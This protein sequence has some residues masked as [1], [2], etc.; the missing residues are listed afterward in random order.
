MNEKPNVEIGSDQELLALIGAGLDGDAPPARVLLVPWGAVQSSSGDFVVDEESA[1]LVTEAFGAHG[2]DLPID[3]EHQTL[4]GAYTSPSGQAPAAGWIKR[5]EVEEGVGIFAEVAWTPPAA[6]QL[7]ARQYRYLSPVALIRKSDRRL[8]A[9][10]SAALTNKPAIAH[11][12][13]IVNHEGTKG[14]SNC[15]LRISDC[16]LCKTTPS[17]AQVQASL[18]AANVE[19]EAALDALRKGLALPADCGDVEVVAAA[20]ARL[21]QETETAARRAAEDRVAE[22]QRCGKLTAAQRDWAVKLAMSDAA[23]FEEWARTAPVV[24]PLGRMAPSTPANA[25]EASRDRLAAGA[26]AEFR[27]NPAL[28][29]ITSE[30]AYVASSLR[31]S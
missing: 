18:A 5:L 15:G 26:R 20:R 19:L 8:V 9:L 21:T 28:A 13:P 1:R 24:V 22:A 31:D 6:E 27:A 23:M 25:A 2:T 11:M 7:A 10:H 29:R 17:V 4:G 30:D 12:T 3:Y 16:G 14:P